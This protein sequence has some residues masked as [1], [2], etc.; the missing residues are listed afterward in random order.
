MFNNLLFIRKYTGSKDTKV[1]VGRLVQGVVKSIDKTRKVVNLSSDAEEVAKCVVCVCLLFLYFYSSVYWEAATTILIYV[2]FMQTKDLEGIQFNLL[3]PGMMVNAYVRST[4]ENG[5]MLSFLSFFNGTVCL[6]I[7]L[8]LL[9]W[10]CT[11]ASNGIDFWCI[12]LCV[13]SSFCRLIYFIWEKL[14]PI[15]SGKT[16]TVKKGR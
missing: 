7:F 16:S 12:I 14:F 3:V 4:L 15:Q 8:S 5:I 13:C 2:I 10:I 11:Q 1:V 6:P 9:N